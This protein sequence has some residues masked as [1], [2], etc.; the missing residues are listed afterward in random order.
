MSD[1]LCE[2]QSR[3]ERFDEKLKKPVNI[4]VWEAETRQFFDVFA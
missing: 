2:Q 3:T 1:A 4:C